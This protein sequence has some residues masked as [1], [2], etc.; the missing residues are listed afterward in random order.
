MNGAICERTGF[1]KLAAEFI[2]SNAVA[3]KSAV[4]FTRRGFAALQPR[5]PGPHQREVRMLKKIPCTFAQSAQAVCLLSL[6]CYRWE[7]DSSRLRDLLCS[8]SPVH[9]PLADRR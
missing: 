2:G 4:L 7:L 3:W 5:P 6:F 1:M 8:E 9:A